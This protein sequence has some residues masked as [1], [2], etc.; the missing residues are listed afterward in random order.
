[1]ARPPFEF[2]MPVNDPSEV[3]PKCSIEING[4]KMTVATAVQL[5]WLRKVGG[6]YKVTFNEAQQ[7]TQEEAQEANRNVQTVDFTSEHGNAQIKAMA[8]RSSQGMVNSFF[9]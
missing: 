1:M 6:E 2:D 5:G 3:M 8:E 4:K 7:K 9:T